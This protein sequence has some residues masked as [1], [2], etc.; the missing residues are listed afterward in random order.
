[1]KEKMNVSTITLPGWKTWMHEV[2]DDCAGYTNEVFGDPVAFV[3]V[4]TPVEAETPGVVEYA[5][6]AVFTWVNGSGFD[7]VDGPLGA[8]D[9]LISVGLEPP[10]AEFVNGHR[11]RT[12]N[13]CKCAAVKESAA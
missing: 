2:C 3:V 13:P 10:P 11:Q 9:Q 12:K 1:M 6:A 8:D 5:D 7:R 4:S